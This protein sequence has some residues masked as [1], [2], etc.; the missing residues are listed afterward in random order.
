MNDSDKFSEGVSDERQV[1]K[2]LGTKRHK[3]SRRSF[4]LGEKEDET[5]GRLMNKSQVDEDY[6]FQ[7]SLH[8]TYN[9]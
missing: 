3:L 1:K 8:I 2:N 9:K 6:M 4:T 7:M 5:Y